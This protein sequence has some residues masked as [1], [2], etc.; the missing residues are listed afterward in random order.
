M[1]LHTATTPNP[2]TTIAAPAELAPPKRKR[3]LPSP[4][5]IGALV[6]LVLMIG[7][8]IF[9]D[10][11][12][13]Y[14]PLLGNYGAVRRPPSFDNLLGT[15]DLGRDVLSR[16]IHGAR[17]SLL[18]AFTAVA[19]GDACG[20]LWGLFSGYA[21]RN[22]DLLSQRFLEVFLAFPSLILATM[23]VIAL[24]AGLPTVI[25]AIAITRM[26]ASTR[27]IRSVVLSVREMA[28]VDAA[29]V[30]GAT[31]WRIMFK[32]IAPQCVAPFLVVATA[33]L[34]IAI[35]TE[36]ALSFLGVGVPPPAPSWGT[37]LGGAS[38]KFNP[39]WWTAVFP[40]LAITLTVLAM[41]L[42]GDALRDLL[43]PKLRGRLD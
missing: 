42:A 15:D 29:R 36:A 37:M 9:A 10:Q 24:G 39:L 31:P 3:A 6:V 32:H 2:A 35:S 27:V 23:F 18:V 43:D 13:P 28:Y 5:T 38:L 11:V 14:D 40:G 22:F 33:N 1:T 34:G 20:F 30:S 12:A 7:V 4:V 41:N 25:L 8:A 26:P 19:L 16:L 17:I 21:G